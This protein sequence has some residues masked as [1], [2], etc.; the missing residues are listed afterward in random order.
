M[1]EQWSGH[2][3]LMLLEKS[4]HFLVTFSLFLLGMYLLGNYQSFLD[5]SQAMILGALEI[6]VLVG[7]ILS[8][9]RLLWQFFSWIWLRY[10]K[11]TSLLLYSC[12]FAVN[13]AILIALKFITTWFKY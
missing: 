11:I 2:W 13:A 3:L 1:A 9:Y 7:A 6:C 4:I 10:F 12:I 5:S 8:C